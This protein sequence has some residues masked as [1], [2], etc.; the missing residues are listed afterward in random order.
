M[1]FQ[2][3]SNINNVSLY[4]VGKLSLFFPENKTRQFVNYYIGLPWL[5]HKTTCNGGLP[6]IT[7][8]PRGRGGVKPPIQFY[9]VLHAKRGGGGPNSM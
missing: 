7:Y 8:A 1:V 2:M 4:T 5:I 6:L 9:C 3:T